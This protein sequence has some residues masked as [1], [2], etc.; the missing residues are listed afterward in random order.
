[1]MRHAMMA[2]IC[3][4]AVWAQERGGGTSGSNAE[5]PKC[6]LEKIEKGKGRWCETC[7]KLRAK[8]ELQDN[9]VCKE[10][11][12]RVKECDVCVKTGWHCPKCGKWFAKEGTCTSD[13]CK[14]DPPKLEKEEVRCR[15]IFKCKGSCMQIEMAPKKCPQKECSARGK[16]YEKTCDNSGQPPH[17]KKK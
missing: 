14:A 3:A 9:W 11:T 2:L 10:C 13:D 6:D 7:R 4:G 8:E 16:D 1:M 5:Q 12:Q 15:V 17:L